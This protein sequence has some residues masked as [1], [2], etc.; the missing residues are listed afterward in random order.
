MAACLYAFLRFSVHS[1]LG[2]YA[3]SELE[4]AVSSP[5]ACEKHAVETRHGYT[6]IYSGEDARN[7]A[8]SIRAGS[9]MPRC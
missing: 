6:H 5:S 9:E 4:L 3:A 2:G 8:I 7:G 1:F